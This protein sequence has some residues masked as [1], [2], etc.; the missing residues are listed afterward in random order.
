M[1]TRDASASNNAV[2]PQMFTSSHFGEGKVFKFAGSSEHLELCGGANFQIGGW[3]NVRV[4]SFPWEWG[5]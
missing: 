1:G 5:N 2:L 4:E 3:H